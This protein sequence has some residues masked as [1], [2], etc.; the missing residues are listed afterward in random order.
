MTSYVYFPCVRQGGVIACKV[1]EMPYVVGFDKKEHARAVRA[2]IQPWPVLKERQWLVVSKASGPGSEL[3]LDLAP[4]DDFLSFPFERC[5]GIVYVRE[6]VRETDEEFL[7]A[8]EVNDPCCRPDIYRKF[9]R[10]S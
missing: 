10:L 1:G 7:F 2:Y 3:D 9:M 8:C 4:L 6:L 5:L